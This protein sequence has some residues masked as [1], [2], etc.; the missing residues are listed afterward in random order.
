MKKLS[1]FILLVFLSCVAVAQKPDYSKMSPLVRRVV[2]ENG[3]ADKNGAGKVKARD[4]RRTERR[5]LFL[6]RID[7]DAEALVARY[8]GLLHAQLGRVSVVSMPV[9]MLGDFSME[10]SVQRMEASGRCQTLLD[11]TAIVV[12]A[13]PVYAGTSLP[14]PYTGKDVVMG[15]M[16]IGFDL[17]HPTFFDKTATNYRIKALWDQL[18]NGND[19][20]NKNE[21]ANGNGNAN[22]LPIGKEYVGTEALLALGHSFDGVEQE[23][24][25]HT[26]G[27][28]AGG[29]YDT[30][31]RGMAWESDICLVAN[32]TSNNAN[33]IP[34]SLLDMYNSTMDILGFKYIFDYAE[35]VGKPCVI[36]FSEG[37]T[38]DLEGEDN[39]IYEALEALTGP[40]RIIVASA[41]NTGTERHYFRKPVGMESMGTFV[42]RK[43]TTAA[44]TVNTTAPFDVRM[45]V[46]SEHPDTIVYHFDG[47]KVEKNDTL[48][49]SDGKY[50][51]FVDGHDSPYFEGEYSGII[52]IVAPHDVGYDTPF[53]VEVLGKEADVEFFATGVELTTNSINVELSAGDCSHGTLSPGSAPCVICVGANG[54]RA[55][56]KNYNNQWFSYDGGVEGKIAP[57]SS[58]GPTFDRRVKP[59]VV[60]PGLVI[61][62]LN[63]YNLEAEPTSWSAERCAAHTVWNGRKYGWCVNIGT[64][65]STPVVGG[66]V[67][68]WLEANPNL[69]PEDIFDIISKTSRHTDASLS[70]PNNTY[71]YGEI[72]VYAGLV[73]ALKLTTT[74]L[75]S[76]STY[77][78]KDVTYRVV[79]GQLSLR[80]L[81]EIAKPVMVSVYSTNG[82]LMTRA[83]IPSGRDTYSI[84]LSSLSHGIYAVQIEGEG[85]LLVRI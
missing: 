45:V 26:A 8:D 28:A 50:V 1:A 42:Q 53:S 60:A 48:M 18:D 59:D 46:Y 55:K 40:G 2:M 4:T 22:D 81:S 9:S 11:T 71:G 61:S 5:M 31:Y 20:E 49:L 83:V 34:E 15:V 33:L 82:A 3:C 16:D 76:I 85:S 67:A 80:F 35:S 79:D 41:G 44:Y 62:A 78:P 52:G 25:T 27:I 12:D 77:Q 69:T 38:E 39:L 43:S 63:S 58:L 14:Q 7:S 24:G 84:D 6:A 57:Y 66:A 36:S 21:N 68:L 64:S 13:Q 75:E 19:N 23:H 37:S 17:T 10:H 29:G 47:S 30:P 73:E 72:D 65:M 54:Y 74:G 32:A 56:V 51:F 70:Y